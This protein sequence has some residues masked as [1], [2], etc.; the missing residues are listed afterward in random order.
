MR[1]YFGNATIL[2][3]TILFSFIVVRPHTTEEVV[4]LNNE[5]W[6]GYEEDVGP[7]S[8]I[9]SRDE[10]QD[11][12]IEGL[13]EDIE[14][15]TQYFIAIL[16]AVAIALTIFYSNKAKSWSAEI[17]AYL[18]M[19]REKKEDIVESEKEAI[20]EAVSR[21]PEI[22]DP[23]N[24]GFTGNTVELKIGGPPITKEDM[25][26]YY[27]S[28]IAGLITDHEF[29]VNIGKA[30]Y[31]DGRIR[32]SINIYDSVLDRGEENEE[33]Y[34]YKGVALQELGEHYK[35]VVAYL[36]AIRIKD[37]FAKAYNNKGVAHKNLREYEEAIAA[38]DMAIYKKPGLVE[39]YCNK[40]GV[41]A[42]IGDYKKAIKVLN[43]AVDISPCFP[44]TYYNLACAYSR[45]RKKRKMLNNLFRSITL[46]KYAA[47]VAKTDGAFNR[48]REYTEFRRLVYP[49]EFEGEESE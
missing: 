5:A 9:G 8:D 23:R 40:G 44:Q 34:F 33:V 31:Y 12:D 48:Y 10:L 29:L 37:D 25:E 41:L 30:F 22:T 16:T 28:A 47:E 19:V 21:L 43:I 35:A 11:Q 18:T 7:E 1:Y 14:Y 2:A 45:M 17:N 26:N 27:K 15:Q 49:E 36:N 13:R 24:V 6:A 42:L 32:K 20:D 3:F 4:T 38:F 46:D 39:A